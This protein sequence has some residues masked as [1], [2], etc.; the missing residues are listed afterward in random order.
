MENSNVERRKRMTAV[1]VKVVSFRTLCGREAF[2]EGENRS[3]M[4]AF[5]LVGFVIRK[6]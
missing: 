3:P 6:C 2:R 1:S 4:G 5:L